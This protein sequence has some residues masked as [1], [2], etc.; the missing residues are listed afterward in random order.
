MTAQIQRGN[1]ADMKT[2][3][4]VVKLGADFFRAM[5]K[6]AFTLPLN[7]TDDMACIIGLIPKDA[8]T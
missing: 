4:D 5:P 1:P 8:M 2:E 7:N 3:T 6:M